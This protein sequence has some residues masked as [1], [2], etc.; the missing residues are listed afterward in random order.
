MS[1]I[2][3]E[4]FH[5]L[6]VTYSCTMSPICGMKLGI[7]VGCNLEKL[8]QRSNLSMRREDAG[9]LLVKP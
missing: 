8:L 6:L 4:G 5:D 2:N 7:W 1:S 3:A 9:M